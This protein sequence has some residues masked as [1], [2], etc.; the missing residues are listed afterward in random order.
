M[1][2]KNMILPN[3]TDTLVSIIVPCYN[4]GYFLPE[5][6][7]SILAQ[8]YTKWE[9]IIVDDGST[10][11]TKDVATTYLIT[12]QR[13]RYIYQNNRG[14]SAARNTGI[15]LSKGSYIQFL[16]ADDLLQEKKLESQICFL[17][18]HFM[19]ILYTVMF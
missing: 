14:L 2:N 9:C 15:K 7:D 18:Q 11:N 13:F 12:D 17:E 1:E 10:D 19:W 8:S 16:D 6:L 3:Y 5:T 4:Y